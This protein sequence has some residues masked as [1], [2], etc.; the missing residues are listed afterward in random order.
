VYHLLFSCP[1]AVEIWEDLRL[2]SIIN[3]AIRVDRSGFIVLEFLLRRSTQTM[4]NLPQVGIRE[5]IGVTCW[6][7][8][9]LRRQRVHGDPVPPVKICVAS[10]LGLGAN[11]IKSH[12]S[13][14]I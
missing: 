11:C 14:T 1:A 2:T 3:E 10:I 5:V 4:V 6:Y 12:R 13:T 8:W 7:L 9:W